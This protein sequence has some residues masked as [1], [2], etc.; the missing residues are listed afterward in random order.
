MGR[1]YWYLRFG[2]G[3]L[4]YGILVFK[5][6]HCHE[7]V[8]R[9][10]HILLILSSLYANGKVAAAHLPAQGYSDQP[11]VESICLDSPGAGCRVSSKNNT[12]L[13]RILRWCKYWRLTSIQRSNIAT[14]IRLKYL[15]DIRYVPSAASS[16]LVRLYLDS[17]I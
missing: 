11:K 1:G 7:L 14:L 5:H 3:H 17:F 6:G 15:I 2:D 4:Q 8:L 10:E 9:G 16:E 13:C 12:T